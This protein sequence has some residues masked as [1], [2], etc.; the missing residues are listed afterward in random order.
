M[1]TNHKNWYNLFIIYVNCLATSCYDS[2]I[3]T[4]SLISRKNLVLN[5]CH[6]RSIMRILI[7]LWLNLNIDDR[8]KNN[9]TILVIIWL[10]HYSYIAHHIGKLPFNHKWELEGEIGYFNNIHWRG[11][12]NNGSQQKKVLSIYE[13]WDMNY[14]ESTRQMSISII[15][16]QWSK[17][18]YS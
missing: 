1:L 18:R 13:L 4:N 10:W 11:T 7:R 9:D 12:K 14:L 16:Y 3:L 15:W 17:Q 5:G 2:W 6:I 8:Y